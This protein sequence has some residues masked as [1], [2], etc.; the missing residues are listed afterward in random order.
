[1]TSPG[2][3]VLTLVQERDA[4]Y[5]HGP[6]WWW[7][8][9]RDAASTVRWRA[10]RSIMAAVATTGVRERAWAAGFDLGLGR[11]GGHFWLSHLDAYDAGNEV[12]REV[13][14]VA[15]WRRDGRRLTLRRPFVLPDPAGLANLVAELA[16]EQ[17]IYSGAARA[18][19]AFEQARQSG[20]SAGG[21]W[22]QLRRIGPAA[23]LMATALVAADSQRV[24][25]LADAVAPRRIVVSEG[26]HAA[27]PDHPGRPRSGR[28]QPRGRHARTRWRSLAARWLRG[29]IPRTT[30]GPLRTAA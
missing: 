29:G 19:A 8:R 27:T 7:F 26:R 14:P 20:A 18:E 1:V 28:S 16:E 2:R 6:R 3:P 17:L 22:R 12:A 4:P 11:Y 13:V 5:R 15:G 21:H 23:A 24:T 30:G 10:L 25:A 9:V